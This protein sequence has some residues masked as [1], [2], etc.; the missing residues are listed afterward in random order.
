MKENKNHIDIFVFVGITALLVFSLAAVYSASSTFSLAKQNDFNYF[1]RSNFLTIK[2]NKRLRVTSS[3]ICN[4]ILVFR[5]SL[6]RAK[7]SV[8]EEIYCP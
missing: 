4:S 6:V 1:F 2:E 5:N 7:N 3:I 8:L